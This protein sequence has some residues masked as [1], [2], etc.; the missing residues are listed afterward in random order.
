MHHRPPSPRHRVILSQR[1]RHTF[2]F[3]ALTPSLA[4]S[5]PPIVL[6]GKGA[7][8]PRFI[9]GGE[10]DQVSIPDAASPATAAPASQSML[11]VKQARRWR[12]G[13]GRGLPDQQDC[14]LAQPGVTGAPGAHIKPSVQLNSF[15]KHCKRSNNPL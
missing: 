5:P 10:K 4:Q 7:L 15:S 13:G 3:F 12:G 2:C 6:V 9:L 8:S 11:W 14:L 1:G